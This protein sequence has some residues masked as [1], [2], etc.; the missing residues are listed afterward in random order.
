[1]G[2]EIEYATYVGGSGFEEAREPVL[3]NGGRLLFGARTKSGN[4]RTTP[5]AFQR[6]FG[7]GVGDSYLA[8]LSPDGS[9]LEAATYFGGSGME[10]PPYGIAVA[11]DGDIVFGSGTTSPNI[12]MTAG[13]YRPNLH[14]PVP[15]P[16]GGY[17]CRISGD[18]T[19]LRWCTYTGG[20]WPRG[21]MR[22]DPDQNVLVVGR[23]TGANFTTTVGVVQRQAL[24]TDDA[25]VLKLNSDGTDI[26]FSTRLG[27]RSTEVG[28]V[29]LSVRMDAVG[30][31]YVSGI[32]TSED[33]PV[34]SGAAQTVSRGPKDGFLAKLNPT[35]TRFL[36]ST[37]L[38][39]SGL[40]GCEH[41]SVLIEDGTV[42]CGGETSSG[43]L[44]GGAGRRG[45]RDGF[46][47][48]LNPSGS[49]FDVVRYVGGT[50]DEQ[51]LGP[52][53]DD[54]GNI[55]LFGNTNSTDLA[56]TPDAIQRTY[57]GGVA[58]GFLMVLAPDASSVLF[59]TYL[60]GSGNELIRGVA[61]G[62]SGELYL[63]GRTDSPDF[64]VTTGAVQT[65]L[66]GDSDAFVVKLV[67]RA[68]N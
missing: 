18:L 9:R 15:S 16:G 35:A 44:P 3:L 59:S 42:L 57:A 58:D 56:T 54:E 4:I 36:Y 55:Y 19:T 29:A 28:E 1:M 5:G 20:G 51:Q 52:V 39:G 22:L 31:L 62:P 13:R 34:T 24:G 32:S 60:G 12:P 30:N 49:A 40:E 2:Y 65:S 63:V 23:V 26:V 64:P 43:D 14:N 66:G 53:R 17:V 61:V 27:G 68:G 48:Q 25:F 10:R 46:I 41:Q 37:F 45:G 21:G 8:V 67:R 6:S 38:S 50:A 7:G 47:A 33:F 11:P